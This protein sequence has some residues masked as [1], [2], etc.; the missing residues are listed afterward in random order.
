MMGKS[1]GKEVLGG[2]G[3]RGDKL[4]HFIC[5]V[6]IQNAVVVITFG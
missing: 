1:T 5:S 2:E 3:E 6:L 4:F